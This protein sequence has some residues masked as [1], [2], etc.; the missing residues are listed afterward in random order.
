M[1]DQQGFLERC[2][3]IRKIALSFNEPLIVH[4][5]DADGVS[6]GAL[7]AGALTTM[8]RPFRRE[9]IKKLDDDAI[10]RYAREKEIIFADLG[11][12]N[13]RVNE[14]NDVVV[15][16]HHQ[17]E[18][19]AKPQV[20]PLL[21]GID[22]DYELSASGTSYCV[23]REHPDLAIV[24]AMGDMQKPLRGMNRWVAERGVESGMVR[25]E[26]D[27]SFYG[28]Y[29]RPL[30][31]FIAY[32]DD[33][34]LPGLSYREDKAMEL[35]AELGIPVED[36]QG[37]RRAYA[38]LGDGEKKLLVSALVKTL[39]GGGRTNIMDESYVFPGRPL[40]ETYEA[41]EF[42]TLLNACGRHGKPDVGVRV[43][44]G[45]ESAYEE[46]RTLLQLH[47]RMLRDGMVFASTHLQDLGY[48]H[49]LDARGVIDES[50]IGI[51]CGMALQQSRK[52]VLGFSLG[53]NDTLKISG[54][55]PRTLV[56]QGMNLGALMKDAT[57]KLGGAGGGHRIAAGASIPAGTLNDF[58]LLAGEYMKTADKG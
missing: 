5:Y 30:V 4:H 3:E 36:S 19:I 9:C 12:G 32:S 52:P 33:P 28:R 20:N 40:N 25:I 10:E 23:F 49:L 53:E 24:G 41:N 7:I 44:L 29:C 1:A 18:G 58:L 42:S 13:Q 38:D 34:Y 31:Q 57:E 48:F 11:G 26:N 39:L 16:D 17:T 54:R 35:L 22:G 14:L 2:E 37:K 56:E 6:A 27:I 51:V 47:R 21:F 50:I 8:N 46:A 45:D 43:C 15:I 55:S